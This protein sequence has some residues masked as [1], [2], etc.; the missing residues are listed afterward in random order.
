MGNCIIA[1]QYLDTQESE[2]EQYIQFDYTGDIQTYS[3]PATGWYKLEVWGS[4]GSRRGGGGGYSKGYKKLKSGQ[5]VYICCGGI[6]YNGGAAGSRT[7]STGGGATHM[8]LVTGTLASI[9]YE[10]FVDQGNGLI[11]A[12]GSGGGG[13]D[14]SYANGGSGGGLTGGN[15]MDRS[16]GTGGSQTSGGTGGGS[17]SFG[18]GGSASS[19]GW[20]GGGGGGFYGGGG[21]YTSGVD[22]ADGSG[23]GGSGWIG[24]VDDYNS[25]LTKATQNGA[26]GGNGY[27][28]IT[29]M[30]TSKGWRKLNIMVC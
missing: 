15:G 7:G 23:G 29:P 12:G 21:G 27:A 28:R 2:Q 14:A 22:G 19:S 18:Q 8:A 4:N 10:S 6:P 5:T 24:G 17:G 25:S 20:A 9:G 30:F 11:V 3:I 1:R 16:P 26:N 13:E